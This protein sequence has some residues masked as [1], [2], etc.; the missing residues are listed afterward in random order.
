MLG[1]PEERY[2]EGSQSEL[3]S[4]IPIGQEFSS[5]ERTKTLRGLSQGFELW[6]KA[7]AEVES[8]NDSIM[9]RRMQAEMMDASSRIISSL[10]NDPATMNKPGTWASLYKQQMD[11]A[12]Q[13]INLDF[14][15]SFY[16]GKNRMMTDAALKNLRTQEANKVAL[17]A[18]SRISQMAADETNAA[19]DIAIKSNQFDEAQ[20]IIDDTPYI[21][22]AQKMR[23]SFS[24]DQ[25][26][27]TNMI[28][29]K[30]L[31]D[32]YGL[33]EEIE[34]KG[35]VNDRELNYEQTQYGMNQ[36]RSFINQA[37]KQNYD[38]LVEKFLLSPERFSIDN[39]RKSLEANALNTQQFATLWRMYHSKKANV[40][41]TPAEFSMASKYA[42]SMIPQYQAATPEEKA[43]MINK[44][45]T[46]LSAANFSSL[47]QTSLVNLMVTKTDPSYLDNIKTWAERVWDTGK[48]PL[49]IGRDVTDENGT[50]ISMTE[51]EFNNNFMSKNGQYYLDKSETRAYED[52]KTLAKRYIVREKVPSQ[53]NYSSLKN[54]IAQCRYEATQQIYN[55]MGEHGGQTPS[56]SEKYQILSN[57]ISSVAKSSDINIRG[58]FSY[59]NVFQSD[60]SSID[61]QANSSRL[62]ILKN[63]FNIGK[64]TELPNM[65]NGGYV[66]TLGTSNASV[67]E[68]S[69]LS[70]SNIVKA[71]ANKKTPVVSKE[72]YASSGGARKLLQIEPFYL[73]KPSDDSMEDA[74]EKRARILCVNNGLSD[75]E[76]QSIYSAL[77][78]YW[79]KKNDRRTAE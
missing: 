71:G 41:P 76:E 37:Q 61:G 50:P 18:A 74:A 5:E 48:Y 30:A 21:S 4:F 70:S 24:V 9:S 3:A 33:I 26:R 44:F 17:T 32:P 22:D 13:S 75:E 38:A 51:A 29:E 49:Y 15:D 73:Q 77:I 27:T 67:Y 43:N 14:N 66:I 72:L 69:P 23:A 40:P 58:F 78:A 42:A 65:P 36:A 47:D 31:S 60:K 79:N 11:L 35:T 63:S 28:Q 52:P 55:F 2:A 10:A 7:Q 53:L 45:R 34:T 54:F 12:Q 46:S 25:A 1:A 8:V 19:I 59:K 20:R 68:V 56:E 64:K 39:V 16:V 57:V 6:G 62:Y